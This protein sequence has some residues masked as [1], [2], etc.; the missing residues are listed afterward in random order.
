[1]EDR[2]EVVPVG[3]S[4][5][6]RYDV[7]GDLSGDASGSDRRLLTRPRSEWFST[8]EIDGSTYNLCTIY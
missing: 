3:G 6:D 2:L 5:V 8:V 1:V 7:E 4:G